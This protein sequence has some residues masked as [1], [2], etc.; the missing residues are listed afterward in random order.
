MPYFLL[1]FTAVLAAT[2]NAGG[3]AVLDIYGD[4][5][6]GGSYYVIPE[7]FGPAGG[8][9]LVTLGDRPCPLYIGQESS[10]AEN[11]IP[12]KFSNWMSGVGFV[13]ESED[14]NI[15]MDVKAT[16]CDEPTYWSAVPSNLYVMK[17]Y[18]EAGR[19]PRSGKDSWRSFFQI[20][21]NY[22]FEESDSYNIALCYKGGGC[23]NVGIYTDEHGVRRLAVY[24]SREPEP[25]PVVFVKANETETSFKKTIVVPMKV[26]FMASNTSDQRLTN[27]LTR[28][29]YPPM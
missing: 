11:G 15:D 23:E 3:Q 2:A 17:Y 14:L 7:F 5:I 6:L 21:K 24:G 10:E 25:F 27:L 4:P 18:V 29:L 13:P 22:D 28:E 26:G 9:N 19:K 12:V 20:K 1:A 16:I 8:L